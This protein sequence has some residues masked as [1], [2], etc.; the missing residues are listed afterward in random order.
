M[1][2]KIKITEGMVVTANVRLL[3]FLRK[4]KPEDLPG[5]EIKETYNLGTKTLIPRKPDERFP[6]CMRDFNAVRD[7]VD[8]ILKQNSFY[9]GLIRFVPYSL[10]GE[11]LLEMARAEERLEELKGILIAHYDEI[12]EQWTTLHPEISRDLYPSV[13][14]IKSRIRMDWSATEFTVPEGMEARIMESES[15]Q[16]VL[17]SAKDRAEL[18]E[19]VRQK[20]QETIGSFADTCAVQ[21][22]ERC[23]E[24]AKKLYDAI[25]K[26]GNGRLNGRALKAFDEAAKRMTALN[27]MNDESIQ[28][29]VDE[30]GTL[31]RETGLITFEVSDRQDHVI[32]LQRS[33]RKMMSLAGKASEVAASDLEKA[34]RVIEQ[35]AKAPRES[36][37]T[38]A[39]EDAQQPAAPSRPASRRGILAGVVGSA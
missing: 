23:A 7:R 14:E 1:E 37:A 22:A 29:V 8:Y 9:D 38:P 30:A 35:A 12:Q 6:V 24:A 15:L 19:K 10:V 2:Q 39:V 33:L 32:K 36:E 20:T 13:E 5:A 17:A 11:T 34:A 26:A 27:W 3:T 4:L 31:V 18:V 21:L 16:K 25:V 28:A